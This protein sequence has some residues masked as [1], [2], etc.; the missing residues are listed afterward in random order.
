MK[1]NPIAA[2]AVLAA[3]LFAVSPATGQT[4]PQPPASSA[5]VK[6]RA[7][8]V[9][10]SEYPHLAPERQLLG[11]RND[12]VRMRDVLVQ[13]GVDSG[14][15]KVLAD[16]VPGAELPTRASIMKELTSLAVTAEPGEHIVISFGG[17]G[18]Q[19]PVPPG[20]PYSH[21]EPDGLFEVFLPRDATKWD[22]KANKDVAAIP[23]A[24]AD[25][26]IRGLVDR[27]TARGASVWAIF[28]SCHSATLV[29]SAI[30]ASDEVR[31]RQVTP[32]DLGLPP[33]SLARAAE[34]AKARQAKPVKTTSAQ[35]SG[36]APAG[37][38]VYFYSANT[39]ELAAEAPQPLGH[40]DS[41]PHGVFTFQLARILDGG[42][43]MTYQ[44]LAQQL[45]ATYSRGG[46]AATS[47]PVFTG[48]GMAMPVLGQSA[49]SRRQWLIDAKDSAITIQA[50]LLSGLNP[51][52]VLAVLP[53]A[54]SSDSEA[55]GYIK[56]SDSRP[57]V[58][59]AT[60]TAWNNT[61][62]ATLDAIRK[63]TVARLVEQGPPTFTLSVAVDYSECDAPCTDRGRIEGLKT[64]AAQA[65]RLGR[66][67]WMSSPAQAELKLVPAANWI[68]LLP[69][70][71]SLAQACPTSLK[72]AARSKCLEE[73]ELHHPTVARSASM[74]ELAGA[75]AK[76]VKA[77]NLLRMMART[78]ALAVGKD[79][80]TVSYAVVSKAKPG[81]V[82]WR[83][84]A[85]AQPVAVRDGERLLLKVLNSTRRSHRLNV[86]YLDSK[87][88]IDRKF[89][90]S[91]DGD[92]QVKPGDEA[93]I[94][95]IE[96]VNTSLGLERLLL[97][98]VEID[99][100]TGERLNLAALQQEGVPSVPVTRSDSSD[101]S[102]S[103][104]AVLGTAFDVTRG[105][106][107]NRPPDAFK[108]Q[109]FNLRVTP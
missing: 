6:V 77:Q 3:W 7:L 104:A 21:D 1:N 43:G 55:I 29:R 16:G 56:V 8:L 70:G 59:A 23:N 69:Q 10:V 39:H 80:L 83:R 89:P 48:N 94:S 64:D 106:P 32:S 47:S 20:S 11:P 74:D 33:E 58:S 63:G 61:A 25:H 51:G 57:L 98:A 28:D 38:A 49:P 87:L 73:L 92:D 12:V 107:P 97:L 90:D 26:E 85:L 78:D 75:L 86:F 99:S 40:P 81:E 109:S 102:S 79:A 18:S 30:A 93:V 68:W 52:S 88:G 103:I 13:R 65:Q 95:N 62:A 46:I 101:I 35:G 42:A 17:H 27:I 36:L 67:R 15:I 60:V 71:A 50:G 96:I 41:K 14:R 19:Q 24:I 76:A 45:I 5:P 31:T 105:S 72:A 22:G 9:G 34:R 4:G 54:A 91:F 44:Q 108:T 37:N 82:N 53:Q 66:V 84:F 2:T 100:A